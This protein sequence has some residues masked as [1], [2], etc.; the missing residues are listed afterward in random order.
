MLWL[1]WRQ[2]GYLLRLK[3]AVSPASVQQKH[4]NICSA[5]SLRI[6]IFLSCKALEQMHKFQSNSSLALSSCLPL[7]R[8][9]NILLFQYSCYRSP[10]FSCTSHT[11]RSGIVS[12]FCKILEDVYHSCPS[13]EIS[14]KKWSRGGSPCRSGAEHGDCADLRQKV[15]VSNMNL[16]LPVLKQHVMVH[17]GSA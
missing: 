8:Q 5:S 11:S 6:T 14:L 16:V 15:C 10:N 2:T 13:C 3:F 1:L 9:A 12:I 17:T 4:F 7:K